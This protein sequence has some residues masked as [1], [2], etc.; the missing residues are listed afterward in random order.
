MKVIQV[1]LGDFGFGWLTDVLLKHE[2]IEIVALVDTNPSLLEMAKGVIG[3][4]ETRFFA[5]VENALQEIKADFLINVTPPSVHKTINQIA[6]AYKVPILC[7]KPIAENYKDALEIYQESLAHQVPVMIAENYRYEG[8]I[9]KVKEILDS[10]SLGEIDAI[11]VRFFRHHKM[12]NYHKD[13]EYPLLLDVTIHHMDVMR[14]LTGDEGQE[15]YARSWNPNGSWYKGD[16][17]LD[18]MLTM[19]KGIKI[20][21]TGSLASIQ[22]ETGWMGE[23][24]LEC[25]KGVMTFSDQMITIHDKTSSRII[26]VQ[27]QTDSRRRVLDN[28]MEALRTQQRGETDI[29]DNLKTFGIV[30]GAIR[31]AQK[32]AVVKF[33]MEA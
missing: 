20:T 10:K 4:E 8:I 16:P 18:F 11:H 30:Q 15:I 22:N 19:R 3:L 33:E 21:Y 26:E 29:S 7:E 27:D 12:D 1:G 13:L 24:R 2:Q 5:R 6:F 28:F 9:R 14:Y 25:E 23:W 32:N 17:S 31:S